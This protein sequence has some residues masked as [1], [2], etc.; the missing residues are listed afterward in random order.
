[1]NTD[2]SFDINIKMLDEMVTK[3][4]SPYG[5]IHHA[6]DRLEK[7]GA[8]S[9]SMKEKWSLSPNSLYYVS[10]SDTA[11]VAFTTPS[12]DA[13]NN[14]PFL[15]M[16]AAHTDYPSFRIKPAPDFSKELYVQVNTEG[17]GGAI[18]QT[19]L[20]RPLGV[21]GKVCLKGENPFTPDIRFFDSKK[22]ILYIPSLAIHMNREV[23][24]GVE[25]NKQT[26]LM[27][28]A[29]VISSAMKKEGLDKEYFMS[30]L[31]ESLECEKEDILDFDLTVY[32]AEPGEL[33]GIKDTLYSAPRLDNL[34]S[35]D[36]LI[37]AL[38][39]AYNNR[40]NNCI[41]NSGDCNDSDKFGSFRG[42]QLISLFDHEEIGSSTK[43]GA[44]SAM[45]RDV[46]SRIML[47]LSFSEE[48]MLQILYDSILLSTDVAHGMH[49]NY[50]SKMDPILHPS[51]GNGICI[52]TASQQSYATDTESIAIF[53]A[54]CNSAGVTVQRFVNRSDAAGGSTLGALSQRFLPVRTIDIGVPILAMHSARELMAV[55]DQKALTDA[56]TAFF[57]A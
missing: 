45:L 29:D 38:I 21:S 30:Y 20:D 47:A 49:P 43:Q 34:T 52:K 57:M 14:G 44:A 8:L 9:L 17:Y 1:M 50:I 46:I 42:I 24:K 37:T 19:W 18:L 40:R 25:L 33:I 5:V 22:A 51:L 13:T 16:A 23:N 54:L 36:A 4:T 32:N 31:A 27:P 15:R 39:S 35:C 3:G 55:S 2:S 26:H 53:E 10:T 12:E 7:A 28:I 48:T 56:V 11:I 41:D 6:K